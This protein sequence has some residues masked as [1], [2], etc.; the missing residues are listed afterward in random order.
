M[1]LNSPRAHLL[2]VNGILNHKCKVPQCFSERSY[3]LS[4][5]AAAVSSSTP[6]LFIQEN[7]L[8]FHDISGLP[9]WSVILL[10][11]IGIRSCMTF[12]LAVYQNHIIGRLENVKKELKSIGPELNKEIAIAAKMYGW[13]SKYSRGMFRKNMH[14]H[15]TKLLIRDNCHPFKTVVM[16]FIQVPIWIS[17][18]FSL[19]NLVL[20]LPFNN[21]AAQLSYLELKSG[22]ILWFTDLTVPDVY[23]IPVLLVLV[24]FAIIEMNAF[25][26]LGKTSV[27]EKI[28][29]NVMRL[30]TLL[31]AVA[32]CINPSAV[33]FYW[34]CSSTFG[35]GQNVLL[36]MPRVRR[37]LRIPQTSGESASP[38]Q[39]I[40]RNIK[41]VLSK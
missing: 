31:V 35:L 23:L 1:Y 24:N 32:A 14:R 27:L 17:F 29:V 22:G 21:V 19:R 5:W 12:P 41:T 9:W 6:V 37:A 4:G 13:D 30:V 7:L 3:A 26:R 28:S 39:D 10:S 11:T 2:T 18:S 34:L 16:A 36:L 25:R 33:T 15:Y 40:Y 38:F 8:Y 20:L